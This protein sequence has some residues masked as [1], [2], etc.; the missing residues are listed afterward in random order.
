MI[1]AEH[2]NADS[3]CNRVVSNAFD[4]C[5]FASRNDCISFMNASGTLLIT[6][7]SL[8]VT[9]VVLGEAADGGAVMPVGR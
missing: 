9:V 5:L 1:I 6:V 7:L 2:T 3:N 4:A 8:S